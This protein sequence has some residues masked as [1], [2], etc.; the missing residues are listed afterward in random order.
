[1]STTEIMRDAQGNLLPDYENCDQCGEDRHVDD[2]DSLG[3][4]HDTE[5]GPV[6]YPSCCIPCRDADPEYIF[7]TTGV[8]TAS[9]AG[10]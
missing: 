2:M 5:N 3:G 10:G 8:R 1:M 4:D 9:R 7:W 6:A